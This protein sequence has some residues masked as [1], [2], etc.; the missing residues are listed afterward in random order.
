MPPLPF[1][2]ALPSPADH[3]TFD[4]ALYPPC[5]SPCCRTNL[6]PPMPPRV[7]GFASNSKRAQI[8][9]APAGSDPADYDEAGV[10]FAAFK[11]GS[12]AR[13]ATRPC[14]AHP[15]M[16]HPPQSPDACSLGRSVVRPGGLSGRPDAP[17]VAGSGAFFHC[18]DTPPGVSLGGAARG[19]TYL[20]VFN[21]A[22]KAGGLETKKRE[23]ERFGG[24]HGVDAPLILCTSWLVMPRLLLLLLFSFVAGVFPLTARRAVRSKTVRYPEM[25]HGW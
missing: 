1:F 20:P 18:D 22:A 17:L 15:C 7:F 16:T 19:P 10:L 8:F 14:M 5:R 3:R 25:K 4:A 2:P 21:R 6:P 24:A 9:V 12:V 11:P 13:C 23:K